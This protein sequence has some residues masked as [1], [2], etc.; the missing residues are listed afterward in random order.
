[1][2]AE[3]AAAVERRA[4]A[5]AAELHELGGKLR[6]SEDRARDALSRG[7]LA[8]EEAQAVLR[9]QMSEE[10]A[11]SAAR[12]R[13]AEA[14]CGELRRA[15]ATQTEATA[16]ARARADELQAQLEAFGPR[17]AS[18]LSDAAGKMETLQGQLAA[19]GLA[20]ARAEEAVA[21]AE[22]AGLAERAERAAAAER[23][24]MLEGMV[25]QS[26]CHA[27]DS[28]NEL[29]ATKA[30]A[31]EL[32]R[33]VQRLREAEGAA[34]AAVAAAEAAAR[35][36]AA[37]AALAVA[38]ELALAR[39][40]A[41]VSERLLQE[42]VRGVEA[43]W[44]AD[45]RG[46]A[47]EAERREAG[48]VDSLSQ[49]A[50]ALAQHRIASEALALEAA[51]LRQ[52]ADAAAA[53]ARR[54]VS[55]EAAAVEARQAVEREAG[56]LRSAL[57]NAKRVAADARREADGRAATLAKQI[58]RQQAMLHEVRAAGAR[59]VSEKYET[60]LASLSSQVSRMGAERGQLAG[61]LN[62]S[63]L[64]LDSANTALRGKD[65][66]LHQMRRVKEGPSGLADDLRRL[67]SSLGR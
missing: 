28:A 41:G 44:R 46:L 45:V 9:L 13:E 34:R 6:S 3:E 40:Q 61:M 49:T 64:Q 26:L 65:H 33:E 17:S 55:A 27:M 24:Q 7:R 56:Q 39:S 59:E 53:E 38:P 60:A 37:A 4:Q 58:S 23:V 63:R 32:E 12:V 35:A 54:A 11:A 16:E 8:A 66:M 2:R 15:L 36:A 30:R 42:E 67:A 29:T 22:A 57:D 48:A 21:K 14:A 19:E 47:A 31:T 52:R 43:A 50:E 20:R 62:L 51:T 18:L 10:A 5:L 25:Q 1:M